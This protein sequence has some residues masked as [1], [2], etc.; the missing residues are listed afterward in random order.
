MIDQDETTVADRLYRTGYT[1]PRLR[2]FWGST[3]ASALVRNNAAPAIHFCQKVLLAPGTQSVTPGARSAGA[4]ND[5][6][7]AALA[8][9]FHFHR[10]VST[11]WVRAALGEDA[12]RVSIDS[13]LIVMS[14]ETHASE[15]ETETSSTVSAPYAI[16]PYD[17]PVGVPRGFRPGD[18]NVYLVSDH[19]TL[20]NPDV[21]DGDFVLGLGG[22]GRT[23][24]SLTP[25]DRVAVSADIGTGCGI[26]ALLLARHSDQVIATDISDRALFLAGLSARLNGVTNIEF[27]AG[28]MLE[29]LTE[30]VDLLVSNPPFVIT[31]R[32][33]VTNFEYRDGGMSGDRLVR[34]LFSSIPDFLRANGRSVCLGN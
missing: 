14:R 27:R 20:V 13:G 30:P 1:E 21:L 32:T 24:V 12:F 23:L 11:E 26:Q 28:S 29:P 8:M 19:G 25:R 15:A 33:T 3:I 2:Q 31:P 18:E 16:T 6:D 22:A 4:S 34:F 9:L 10:D 17:L 7:L 5:Y